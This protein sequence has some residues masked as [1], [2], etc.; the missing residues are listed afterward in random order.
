MSQ[1]LII[2]SGR[3]FIDGKETVDV[4]LIGYTILDAVEN[5][6]SVE[7][8]KKTNELYNNNEI[9]FLVHDEEQKPRMILSTIIIN[10]SV[11]YELISGTEVSNHFSHELSRIKQVF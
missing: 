3:V 6:Y 11:M 2:D 5:G 9:V 4:N 1:P 7:I 8:T 10:E